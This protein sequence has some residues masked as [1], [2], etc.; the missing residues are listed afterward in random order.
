MLNKKLT[1]LK[2]IRKRCI[3]CAGHEL[4]RVKD[5]EFI[6]CTLYHLRMGKGSRACLRRIRK[7]C[8]WCCLD[9]THE[10]RQCPAVECA[11]WVY[12]FGKR[13]QKHASLSEIV[14]TEGVL[15]TEKI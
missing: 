15:E 11:L 6:N 2:A 7:Y 4:T 10:V 14:T 12:R 5:C 13:P 8:T 9:Q 3:D 1:P